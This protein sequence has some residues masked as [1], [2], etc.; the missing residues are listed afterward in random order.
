L[1][2][3][4]TFGEKYETEIY[5]FVETGLFALKFQVLFEHFAMKY[6]AKLF[7]NTFLRAQRK[8]VLWMD[9]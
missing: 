2:L 7:F 8:S 1:R 4:D 5:E 6:D 9:L 3:L